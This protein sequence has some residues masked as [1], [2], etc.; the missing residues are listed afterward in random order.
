MTQMQSSCDIN[1]RQI[2]S[3]TSLQNIILC[4]PEGDL[5]FQKYVK[6]NSNILRIKTL[7]T[8]NRFDLKFKTNYLSENKKKTNINLHF[9]LNK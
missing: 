4:S 5:Y 3:T 1:F 6:E 7:K 9:L 8:F 2:C